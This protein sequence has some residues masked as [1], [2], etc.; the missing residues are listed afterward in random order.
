M[1]ANETI[2]A[3]VTSVRPHRDRLRFADAVV[4]WS[5]AEWEQ[6]TL[7]QDAISQDDPSCG[8]TAALLA[9]AHARLGHER[10]AQHCI[11]L[12]KRLGVDHPFL[13]D[14]MMATAHLMLARI[15][16]FA[17]DA[18]RRDTHYKLASAAAQ[19]PSSLV[20]IFPA[21]RLAV[22]DLS[23]C[24]LMTDA[25]DVMAA[26]IGDISSRATV[27]TEAQIAVVKSEVG[28][29]RQQLFLAQTRG[30]FSSNTSG[31]VPDR[32]AIGQ[33]SVSQ[34]G[35]DLW[36]LERTNFKRGGFFVEFGATDGVS[37]S[38]T[39]LLEREFGWRGLL[40]EPHPAYFA[41]L[42]RNRT[43]TMASVCIG[44]R[45]GDEVEFVL[46][47]EFS[48]MLRH[49]DHDSNASR[50][51]AY[52]KFAE[53]ILTLK[54]ISLDEFL[55][56]HNA[57]K[58][59]DYISVDTEGSELEILSSFPFDKWNVR[60]WTIEHNFAADRDGIFELMKSHGY[61]RREADWDDWYFR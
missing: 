30:Q 33:M 27:E 57:P 31:A 52:A 37:L 10:D 15:A 9:S 51:G 22:R 50:R 48:G 11:D 24:G 8:R 41:Q 13:I 38:N 1:S 58:D 43:S 5:E 49:L 12:A 19:F 2:D 54:T 47:D 28:L 3:E 20:G 53:N 61:Q 32:N 26:H 55:E 42:Q 23:A 29:L 59:I 36:V 46:A 4:L 45:T 34:L 18:E 56:T 40:A 60:N 21:M 44:Q 35:Q 25:A 6:L 39:Y 14:I 16:A 17:G 7:C